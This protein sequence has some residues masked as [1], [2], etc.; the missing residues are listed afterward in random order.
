MS[1]ENFFSQT[2]PIIYEYFSLKDTIS[3]DSN[4]SKGEL[5]KLK[6]LFGPQDP[7]S[8]HGDQGGV[9]TCCVCLTPSVLS[10]W[11]RELPST[12]GLQA[13]GWVW[14]KQGVNFPLYPSWESMLPWLDGFKKSQKLHK[15]HHTEVFSL[16]CLLFSYWFKILCIFRSLNLSKA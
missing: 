15:S 16:L 1:P 4:E 7:V 13:L 11:L 9:R 8:V 6:D 2:V 5:G 10:W 3:E 14:T 12:P